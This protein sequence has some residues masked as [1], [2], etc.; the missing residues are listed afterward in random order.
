MLCLKTKLVI[1][2]YQR[3]AN[4]VSEPNPA[5]GLF[6]YRLKWFLHLQSHTHKEQVTELVCGLQGL[7]YYL[8]II[9]S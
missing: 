7:K 2:L 4:Y 3:L 5:Y 6:L 8:A 9:C 1:K